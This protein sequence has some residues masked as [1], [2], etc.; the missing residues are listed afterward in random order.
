MVEPNGDGAAGHFRSWERYDGDASGNWNHATWGLL[1][2][3]SWLGECDLNAEFTMFCDAGRARFGQGKGMMWYTGDHRSLMLN[4]WGR[5]GN[6]SDNITFLRISVK[7]S[8]G[9][10]TGTFSGR[11]IVYAVNAR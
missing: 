10:T 8:S 11:F 7:N 2:G 5:W 3:R 6:E 9:V 1:F 4:S